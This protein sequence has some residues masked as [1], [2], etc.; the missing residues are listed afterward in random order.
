MRI[1]FPEV[2]WI[3]GCLQ[4]GRNFP[5]LQMTFKGWRRKISLAFREECHEESGRSACQGR[6]APLVAIAGRRSGAAGGAQL[7]MS[8][9][10]SPAR[11]RE[12]SHGA[13]P[14]VVVV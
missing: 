14:G 5:N 1:F 9:A 3:R 2:M 8:R 4:F 6:G 11:G 10:V 7:G 12:R 13:G